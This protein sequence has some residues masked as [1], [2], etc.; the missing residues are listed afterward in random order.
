MVDRVRTLRERGA[1]WTRQCL[2]RFRGRR[3]GLM[4]AVGVV[5]ANVDPG[6]LDQGASSEG[7]PGSSFV[8]K[9]LGWGRWGAL[10]ACVGAIIAGGAL[11]GWS[12]YGGGS[13]H[14]GA[15]GKRYALGGVVGAMLAGLAPKIVSLLYT[16]AG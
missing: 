15:K 13:M 6:N 4:V 1:G 12:E 8:L 3:D 11:Y 9:L 16:Q 2:S 7:L 5:W 14:S 10:V